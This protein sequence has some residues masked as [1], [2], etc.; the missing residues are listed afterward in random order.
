M[1]E[2]KVYTNF[3][4][5][6]LQGSSLS[7]ITST[8]TQNKTL[9]MGLSWDHFNSSLQTKLHIWPQKLGYVSTCD[10]CCKMKLSSM[11][12]GECGKWYHRYCTGNSMTHF[13]RLSTTTSP[14]VCFPCNQLVQ[15]AKVSQLLSEVESL[16]SQVLKLEEELEESQ[17]NGQSNQE[18]LL[19]NGVKSWRRNV[20]RALEESQCKRPQLKTV[21]I[22]TNRWK[23]LLPN[24]KNPCWLETLQLN[25]PSQQLPCLRTVVT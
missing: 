9:G 16:K 21:R 7:L 13:K 5:K 18:E 2:V 3:I 11:C 25:W 12:E 17:R 8:H 24:N 6:F 20:Q 1:G 4:K 10:L 23:G 14:F 15:E 22:G 19:S